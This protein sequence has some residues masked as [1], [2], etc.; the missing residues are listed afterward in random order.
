MTKITNKV[1]PMF[2][3]GVMAFVERGI[4]YVS[5]Y[6][7]IHCPFRNCV[8]ARRHVPTVVAS[9]IIHNG[10]EPSYNVWINH[11]E[12]LPGYETDEMNECE[13]SENESND[14]VDELLE[15]AFLMGVDTEAENHKD[16]DNIQPSSQTLAI[17]PKP[18][19]PHRRVLKTL[20]LKEEDRKP[21]RR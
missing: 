8:N 10:F 16:D 9:H 14:G 19:P 1:D 6:G 18:F 11:G 15:D 13:E 5:S 21:P 3:K 2:I 20:E 17:T 7:R 12:H 4:T